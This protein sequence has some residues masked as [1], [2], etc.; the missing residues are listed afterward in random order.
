MSNPSSLQ[1]SLRVKTTT[2]PPA[3]EGHFSTPKQSNVSTPPNSVPRPSHLKDI[4]KPIKEPTSILT[5]LHT[6]LKSPDNGTKRQH[7][8]TLEDHFKLAS[9]PPL[10]PA[11]KKSKTPSLDNPQAQLTASTEA[12]AMATDDSPQSSP[13]ST[14][15]PDCHKS[16]ETPLSYAAASQPTYPTKYEAHQLRVRFT[17]QGFQSRSSTRSAGLQSIIQS[18]L[19]HIHLVDPSAS[20]LPWNQLQDGKV[21]FLHVSDKSQIAESLL[22]SFVHSPYS[23]NFHQGRTHWRQGIR[24]TSKFPLSV[25]ID[26]WNIQRQTC[27][28]MYILTPAETQLHH[29]HAVVG[30]CQGSTTKK[31]VSFLQKHLP[32]VTGVQHI[33]ISWQT[34]SMG[35][36]T[37]AYWK[38][39]E[40]M[41]NQET[42]NASKHSSKWKAKK[43]A[44]SPQ[45]LTIYAP[46]EMEAQLARRI[47]YEKYGKKIND[48]FPEWPDGSRM[49]FL[50]LATGRTPDYIA[51]RMEGRF[52]WHIYAKANEN[53][54][55]LNHVNPWTIIPGTD[56]TI[57]Q[58][59]HKVTDKSAPIFRHVIRTWTPNPEEMSWGVT[60]SSQMR[61]VA[62]KFI[63]NLRANIVTTFGEEAGTIIPDTVQT[64]LYPAYQSKASD[65]DQYYKEVENDL[66][67]ERLLEPGFVDQ[68]EADKEMNDIGAVDGDSTIVGGRYGSDTTSKAAAESRSTVGQFSESEMEC[69]ST[70]PDHPRTRTV[71]SSD[72]SETVKSHTTRGTKSIVAF[73]QSQSS[74]DILSLRHTRFMKIE[75]QLQASSI[76]VGFFVALT[77]TEKALFQYVCTVH[78]SS[79]N[80]FITFKKSLKNQHIG[81]TNKWDSYLSQDIPLS[82]AAKAWY[83]ADDIPSSPNTTGAAEADADPDSEL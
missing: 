19:D 34:V 8:R 27:A 29:S 33:D 74:S 32:G 16:P 83:H 78:A 68:L 12:V 42:D 66:Q 44:H 80:R 51:Q 63:A 73:D 77:I 47:L 23:T 6:Q 50:P 75:A 21:P 39:A 82:D 17:V 56:Y 52:K 2:N 79:K 57:G 5:K 30:I 25:F 10:S 22:S 14:A 76:G 62:I 9:F 7:Q 43:F 69:Q 13:T 20:L 48:E 1:S 38:H 53:T 41:A 59:L 54:V 15:P 26:K 72:D 11:S 46:T 65:L 3:V 4:N 81:A 55:A 71:E 58:F 49:K 37:P 67:Y 35:K 28:D 24:I 64:H 40:V 45:A 60:Y 31:D 18:F 61:E 70:S 36:F